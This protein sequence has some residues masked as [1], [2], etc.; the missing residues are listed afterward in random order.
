MGITSDN[1]ESSNVA[2]G[3][4]E[5]DGI[6]AALTGKGSKTQGMINLRVTVRLG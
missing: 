2:S 3:P 5:A 4:K 1:S 6:I